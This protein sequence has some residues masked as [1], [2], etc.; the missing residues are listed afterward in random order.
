MS[1]YRR[2]TVP[3]AAYFFTLAT[4]RRQPLLTKSEV[5]AALRSAHR[6]VRTT[7]PFRVEAMV[8]LPDHLHAVWTLPLEDADYAIRW[9]LI[10]RH[11][12]QAVR[13]LLRTSQSAS[14]HQRREIALWQRRFWEHQIRDETDYARHVDYIHYNPVKHG[15]VSEVAEWTYSTFHR[16]VRIGRLSA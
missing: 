3:G 12:S 5:L 4:Y 13:H 15:L 6:M 1:R 9:S 11:V 2:P 14:R 10:K 7:R 16:F 8:V